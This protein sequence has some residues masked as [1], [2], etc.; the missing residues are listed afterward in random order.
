MIVDGGKAMS[1]AELGELLTSYVGWSF[2]LRLGGDPPVRDRDGT[3]NRITV[4]APNAAEQRAA[5]RALRSS[6]GAYIL[7]SAHYPT[8]DRWAHR[9]PE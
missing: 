3:L 5:M 8:P 9:D 2:E 7:D 1:W 4:R 6:D